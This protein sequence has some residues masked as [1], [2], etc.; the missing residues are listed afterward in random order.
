MEHCGVSTEGVFTVHPYIGAQEHVA[1]YKQWMGEALRDGDFS[2]FAESRCRQ[3]L[4]V[5][6][7][8]EKLMAAGR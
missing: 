8:H 4:E 2:V 3:S 5:F 7:R 1:L 6:K